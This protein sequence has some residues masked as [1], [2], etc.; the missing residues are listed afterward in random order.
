[1][2]RDFGS[3][4]YVLALTME[5]F[6]ALKQVSG[7]RGDSESG[8]LMRGHN[9]E[10]STRNSICTWQ[11]RALCIRNRVCFSICSWLHE[12]AAKDCHKNSYCNGCSCG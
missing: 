10:E 5:T 9:Q 7:L 11:G 4:I 12:K 1:M 8:N 6:V 3:E 2:S